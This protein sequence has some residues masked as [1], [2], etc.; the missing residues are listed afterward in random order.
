MKNY[1]QSYAPTKFQALNTDVSYELEVLQ[2]R[3]FGIVKRRKKVLM[4]LTI[5]C[6][7]QSYFDL[8]DELIKTQKPI[9]LAKAN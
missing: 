7:S 3:F 9:S 5:H 2:V 1:L 6:D 4:S 8:W